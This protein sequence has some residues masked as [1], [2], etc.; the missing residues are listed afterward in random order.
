MVWDKSTSEQSNNFNLNNIHSYMPNFI[1]EVNLAHTSKVVK[2]E[3][4]E[5]SNEE[6]MSGMYINK[7]GIRQVSS[8]YNL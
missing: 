7:K 1:T 3:P 8:F 5:D 6:N 2:I 4:F